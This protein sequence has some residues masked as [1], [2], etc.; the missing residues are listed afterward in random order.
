[1]IFL[2]VPAAIGQQNVDKKAQRHYLGAKKR[3]IHEDN[4]DYQLEVGKMYMKLV[5]ENQNWVA[6]NCIEN[7][8]MRSREAIH[9]EII[10][11]LKEKKII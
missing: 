5:E 3:D 4:L 10:Q 6:I 8:Q 9:Q 7:E 2:F 11:I 1:M